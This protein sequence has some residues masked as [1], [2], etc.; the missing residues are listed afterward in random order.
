MTFSKV[1]DIKQQSIYLPRMKKYKK[2]GIIGCVSFPEIRPF[3]IRGGQT[4]PS[5]SVR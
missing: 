4:R 2:I 5:G 1:A 3:K